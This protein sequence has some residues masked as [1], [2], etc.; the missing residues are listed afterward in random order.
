MTLKALKFLHHLKGKLE[1]G[2][3]AA[4]AG[5]AEN[6]LVMSVSLIESL[7]IHSFYICILA[8][9]LVFYVNILLFYLIILHMGLQALIS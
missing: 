7:D 5:Y 9:F 6:S 8:L 4:T 2:M 1:D 3:V